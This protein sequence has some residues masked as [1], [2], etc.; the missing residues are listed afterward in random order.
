MVLWEWCLSVL[1]VALNTKFF[2][3]LFAFY[4]M[5]PLVFF[6]MGEGGCGLLWSVEEENENA[7]ADKYKK[8]I[9]KTRFSKIFSIHGCK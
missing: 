3:L 7:N 8:D 6:V 1:V 5:E 2:R 4:F 9:Y